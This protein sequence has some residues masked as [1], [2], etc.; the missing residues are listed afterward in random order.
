MKQIGKEKMQEIAKEV[1]ERFPKAKKVAVVSDGQAFIIDDGDAAAKNHANNNIYGK[2][3]SLGTFLR[4]DVMTKESKKHEKTAGE[5]VDEIE[6]ATT[7]EAVKDILGDSEYKTVQ[8]AA[9]KRISEIEE[10][11]EIASL[12]EAIEQAETKEDVEAILGDDKREELVEAAKTRIS[13]I[14]K[15]KNEDTNPQNEA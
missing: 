9:K 12:I 5:L 15:S 11:Q 3:L 13:E 14:E 8:K 2:E 10:A 6:K 7:I 4:D 1:F